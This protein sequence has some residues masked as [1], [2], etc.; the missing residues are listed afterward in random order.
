MNGE[1]LRVKENDKQKL[2][3]ITNIWKS[4]CEVKSRYEFPAKR[5]RY[6]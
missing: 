2:N 5:A 3:Q 4:P 6:F 1:F